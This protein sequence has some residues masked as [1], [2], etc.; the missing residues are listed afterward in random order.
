M[1]WRCLQDERQSS[2]RGAGVSER[3]RADSGEGPYRKLDRF[4]SLIVEPQV[5]FTRSVSQAETG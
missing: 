1:E 4:R 3:V 5:T 2:E